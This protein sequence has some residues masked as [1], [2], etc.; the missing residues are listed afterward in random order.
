MRASTQISYRYNFCRKK[1]LI[2]NGIVWAEIS[3]RHKESK[4]KTVPYVTL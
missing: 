4:P 1:L 3:F 2:L